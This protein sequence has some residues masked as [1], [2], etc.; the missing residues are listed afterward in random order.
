MEVG[1]YALARSLHEAHFCNNYITLWRCSQLSEGKVEKGLGEEAKP[2]QEQ[3]CY[4]NIIVSN[5]LFTTL[6]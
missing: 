3:I 5:L 1:G 2:H 6:M 4:N